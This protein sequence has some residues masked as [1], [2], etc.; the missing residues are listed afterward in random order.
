[1]IRIPC[2]LLPNRTL[3]VLN[4]GGTNQEFRQMYSRPIKLFK[5]ISN[6]LEFE[7]R[8]NDQ[9]KQSILGMTPVVMLFDAN[10][11]QLLPPRYGELKY[12]TQHI[13]T[14]VFTAA[15]LDLIQ[16]Q[17]LNIVVKV[18]GNGTEHIVYSDTAYGLFIEAELFD[19]YN[20]RAKKDQVISVFNY[21]YNHQTFSG[22]YTSEL[23]QFSANTNDLVLDS[24]RS[25]NVVVYP[26]KFRGQVEIEVTKDMSTANSNNWIKLD[27]KI[28]VLDGYPVEA[29]VSNNEAYTFIRFKFPGHNG[30]GGSFD[31]RKV[32][33]QYEVSLVQRGSGYLVGDILTIKGSRLNGDDG[34]NDLVI[35]VTEVNSYPQGAL[36]KLGFT[37]KGVSSDPVPNEARL[38]RNMYPEPKP[39]AKTLE[40]I[41]VIS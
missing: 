2:Y 25:A 20:D 22:T 40:K 41:I 9:K 35:T 18:V 15:E 10:Q 27:Q 3:V 23:A 37:W 11:Q 29:I 4:T 6:T 36:H 21:N 14:V 7:V 28:D 33:G 24:S 30:Y 17:S 32:D 31:V 8:N 26:G 39:S 13:F 16:C 34:V 19:G 12:G 1:M 38:F 5:G